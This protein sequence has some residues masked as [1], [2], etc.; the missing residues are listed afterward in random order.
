MYMPPYSIDENALK[1]SPWL[2]SYMCSAKFVVLPISDASYT[3]MGSAPVYALTSS[4]TAASVSKGCA[5]TIS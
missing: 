3:A 4:V 2:S 5:H 1:N